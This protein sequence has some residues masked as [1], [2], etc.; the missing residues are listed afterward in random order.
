MEGS[1]NRPFAQIHNTEKEKSVPEQMKKKTKAEQESSGEKLVVSGTLKK[2]RKPHET[3]QREA[4][5][6]DLSK[7]QLIRLLGVMEGE[8]QVRLGCVIE[9]I[10]WLPW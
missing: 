3:R 9:L 8:V 2:A 7:E 6:M 1:E 5:L 10:L 4:G